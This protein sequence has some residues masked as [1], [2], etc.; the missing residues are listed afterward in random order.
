MTPNEILEIDA[1]RNHPPGT[2]AS[3]LRGLINDDLLKG[4]KII[5]QG[6]TL[7]VF[8]A[9]EPGVVE[10]HSFNADTADNLIEVNKDLWRML[11]KIGAKV[12]RTTFENP[13]V[14]QLFERVKPEFDVV[15][16][17]Q[18]GEYVAEVRL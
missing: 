17:Q 9:V 7:I 16:T 14:R 12:A 6:K 18:D 4:G 5:Q 13:K 8:R 3:D 10:H 2:T 11:K 1:A 15:V